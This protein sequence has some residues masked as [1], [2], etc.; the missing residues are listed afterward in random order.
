MSTKDTTN[1][2][3]SPKDEHFIK[4]TT[5][6]IVVIGASGDLAKKKTYP[7]LLH[8]FVNELLPSKAKIWGYA[9]S[10]LS[11]EELRERL[12]PYLLQTKISESKV[13]EFLKLC[14]YQ[15]GESYGDTSAFETLKDEMETYEKEHESDA[16]KFNRLFYF[17]IPPNVFAETGLA[18]KQTSMQERTKGWTRLIVEKPFGK[19]LDS[20]EKLNKALLR[21]SNSGQ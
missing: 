11:N 17:A 7:S 13:D 16:S 3:S 2:S 20:F 10:Q 5:L 12:K 21:G 19:D 9:R 15:G 4:E 18:I 1:D 14:F 6:C 8:L